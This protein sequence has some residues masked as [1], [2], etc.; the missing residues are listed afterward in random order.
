MGAQAVLPSERLLFPAL[1]KH[2]PAHTG[3]ADET[4]GLE[5]C[6]RG[7][8]RDQ[9][10]GCISGNRQNSTT[11]LHSPLAGKDYPPG[12]LLCRGLDQACYVLVAS[13]VGLVRHLRHIFSAFFT[14]VRVGTLKLWGSRSGA[15]WRTTWGRHSKK[16]EQEPQSLGEDRL[17]T[18][19]MRHAFTQLHA[20]SLVYGVFAARATAAPAQTEKPS[21]FWNYLVFVFHNLRPE[22][23]ASLAPEHNNPAHQ[24][25][26]RLLKRIEGH[27][28]IG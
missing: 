19:A 15:H 8:R 14:S 4:A 2:L 13:L 28:D 22:F 10:K 20:S 21:V 16:A 24:Y 11:P 18:E 23:V 7:L 6:H 12:L 27:D 17:A 25:L 5:C 26:A 3:N 9:H 1:W